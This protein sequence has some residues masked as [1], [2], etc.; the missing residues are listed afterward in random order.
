M[1]RSA[2]IL[3]AH[4]ARDA[5][6][7]APFLR[8]LDRVQAAAPERA[9]MLAFLELMKPDLPTAIAQQAARGHDAVTIVPLFLGQ[10]GHLRNDLPRI[11]EQAQ[12]AHP[13]LSIDVSRPAGEDEDV[14][15]AIATFSTTR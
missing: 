12:S 3:F 13:G 8:V 14:I 9:P 4:G 5:S 10:G 15:A 6:W 2:L 1:K 7:A 11:V